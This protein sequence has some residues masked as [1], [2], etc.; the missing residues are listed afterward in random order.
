MFIQFKCDLMLIACEPTSK[1]CPSLGGGPCAVPARPASLGH[2]H[3]Q[4]RASAVP[5][6]SSDVNAG[7]TPKASDD[8]GLSRFP[9][10]FVLCSPHTAAYLIQDVSV[11]FP[12]PDDSGSYDTGLVLSCSVLGLMGVL[13]SG[14]ST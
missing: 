12:S 5:E 7:M 4:A 6:M 3:A 10:T 14:A 8:A 1:V 2:A 13:A 9:K 11:A